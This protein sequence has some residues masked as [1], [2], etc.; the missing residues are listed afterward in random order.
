MKGPLGFGVVHPFFYICFIFQTRKEGKTMKSILQSIVSNADEKTLASYQAS[1]V[2]RAL[3]LNDPD[4]KE[5]AIIATLQKMEIQNDSRVVN[6]KA[7]QFKAQ[8]L[9]RSSALLSLTPE[10]QRRVKQSRKVLQDPKV[11]AS[12]ASKASKVK[13]KGNGKSKTSEVTVQ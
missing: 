10:E 9:S 2:K 13:S 3:T 8:L 1:K 12:K 11:K 7:E 6:A 5:L 4:Q